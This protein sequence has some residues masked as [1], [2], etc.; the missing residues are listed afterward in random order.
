M[1]MALPLTFEWIN[2][3]P[4]HRLNALAAFTPATA[5][6]DGRRQVGRL[7]W[8]RQTGEVLDILTHQN[9]RRQGIATEL[10]HRAVIMAEAEG[11]TRPVHSGLRT[12][13]GEAWVQS[14]GELAPA[15]EE[16]V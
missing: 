7:Q 15:W 16:A 6:P 8:D 5:W 1:G 10:W 2:P 13:A 4:N 11:F 3:H 14:L 9:Y 12:I